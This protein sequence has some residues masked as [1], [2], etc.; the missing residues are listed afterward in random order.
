MKQESFVFY[1][2]FYEAVKEFDKDIIADLM[3]GLCSY[4]LDDEIIEFDNNIAK[5]LF[6]LIKPQIDANKVKRLNGSSGGRPRKNESIPEE[7]E[8]KKPPVFK[9][10]KN[11]KPPVINSHDEIKPP[12]FKNALEKKPNVNVNVN[13]NDNVIKEKINKKEK[14]DVIDTFDSVINGFTN[15]PALKQRLFEYVSMRQKIKKGYTANALRLNLNN[16]KKYGGSDL[17]KMIS[18][19][20]QSI[21]RSYMDFYPLNGSSYSND[22][23]TSVIPKYNIAEKE[24]L[25]KISAMEKAKRNELIKKVTEELN[26]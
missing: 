21:G 13:V 1:R 14:S 15:E 11:K 8:I 7:K 26:E 9:N 19:V 25:S 2:S 20:E 16:L 4:A 6:V 18:I 22:Q 23:K 3:I 24:D 5:S 17:N 10:D 12:V